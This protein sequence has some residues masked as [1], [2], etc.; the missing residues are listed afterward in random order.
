MSDSK[1]IEKVLLLLK[2]GIDLTTQQAALY[3]N[4]SHRTLEKYRI[5][6]EGPRF[7]RYGRVVRYPVADLEIWKDGRIFNNTTERLR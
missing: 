6:G 3:L 7:R 1:Q 4:L 5:T 2:S